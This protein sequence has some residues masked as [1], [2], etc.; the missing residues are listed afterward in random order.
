[1]GKNILYKLIG[2][3]ESFSY[4]V[5]FL[6]KKENSDFEISCPINTVDHLYNLIP[7]KDINYVSRIKM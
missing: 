7:Q 6:F 5:S 1:M 2:V 3:R 4:N